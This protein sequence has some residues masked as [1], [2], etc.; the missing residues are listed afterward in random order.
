MTLRVNMV[1]GSKLSFHVQILYHS[2]LD[3]S[4]LSGKFWAVINQAGHKG[5]AGLSVPTFTWWNSPVP[6]VLLRKC[7]TVASRFY[8]G[9]QEEFFCKRKIFGFIYS[10]Q[11]WMQFMFHIHEQ[12]CGGLLVY[13][14]H[15]GL[16]EGAS[17]FPFHV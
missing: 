14:V 11:Q 8:P 15:G 7:N 17:K 1:K 12:N 5:A 9:I 6:A 16:G 3:S 13:A 10:K 4:V 2:L